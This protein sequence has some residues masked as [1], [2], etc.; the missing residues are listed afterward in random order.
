VPTDEL[1]AALVDTV[2]RALRADY[3]GAP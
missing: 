2:A 3:D 1:A